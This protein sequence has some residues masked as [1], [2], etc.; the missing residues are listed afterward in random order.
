MSTIST[1]R[2]DSSINCHDCSKPALIHLC[3]EHFNERIEERVYAEIEHPR[4]KK[5]SPPL[6]KL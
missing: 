4:G 6:I 2:E 1:Q 3:E 5:I